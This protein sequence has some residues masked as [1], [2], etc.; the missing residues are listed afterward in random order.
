MTSYPYPYP[1]NPNPNP[2]PDQA[3]PGRTGSSW[4]ACP[5]YCSP[6]PRWP[7]VSGASTAH[8]SGARPRR[9]PARSWQSSSL[10][11]STGYPWF[12]PSVQPHLASHVLV[13][14][15][16]LLL[17]VWSAVN[18]RCG[19]RVCLPYSSA[20]GRPCALMCILVFANMLINILYAKNRKPPRGQK[21]SGHAWSAGGPW[22]NDRERDCQIRLYCSSL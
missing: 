19:V 3:T 16:Y 2:T 4:A 15:S 21:N 17:F 8:R 22:N 7:R 13:W 9:R 12:K 1:Y 10:G 18:A 14:G 20:C 11:F 5:R 6:S